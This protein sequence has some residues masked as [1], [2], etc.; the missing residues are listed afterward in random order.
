MKITIINM[1]LKVTVCCALCVSGAATAGIINDLG[2]A[3]QFQ[4]IQSFED[5]NLS[6]NNGEK[7]EAEDEVIINPMAGCPRLPC[8]GNW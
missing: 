3:A 5:K 1:F 7:D 6:L 2:V 8:P 4:N